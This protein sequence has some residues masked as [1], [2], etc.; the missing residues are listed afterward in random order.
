MA[1]P[2]TPRWRAAR[3]SVS[4]AL[5]AGAWIVV[6]DLLLQYRAHGPQ[7]DMHVF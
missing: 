6:S 1:S 5:L 7:L 4:Y 2:L 3:I